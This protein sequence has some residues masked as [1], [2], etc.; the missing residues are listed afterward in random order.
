MSGSQICSAGTYNCFTPPYSSGF[1]VS[2]WS[3]HSCGTHTF[4]L[5]KTC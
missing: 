2:L 3:Y 4:V 1:Q 5:T